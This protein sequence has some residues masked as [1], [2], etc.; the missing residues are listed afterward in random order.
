[1]HAAKYLLITLVASS[2][3]TRVA[4]VWLRRVV[5]SRALLLPGIGVDSSKV[6]LGTAGGILSNTCG[7][8]NIVSIH[9]PH[10]VKEQPTPPMPKFSLLMKTWY[11]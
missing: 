4:R 2:G 3:A 6:T 10:E 9:P 1:M 7:L 5:G 8:W 11:C